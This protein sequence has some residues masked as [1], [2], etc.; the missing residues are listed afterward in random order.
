MQNQFMENDESQEAVPAAGNTSI[1][2]PKEAPKAKQNAGG[3]DPKQAFMGMFRDLKA[4][5]DLL[6]FT[7]FL[8]RYN[9]VRDDKDNDDPEWESV[10]MRVN[11]CNCDKLRAYGRDMN[12]SRLEQMYTVDLFEDYYARLF[13]KKEN[14]TEDVKNRCK[15]CTARDGQPHA[16]C[17]Y[18]AE[19]VIRR[20]AK[21][22]DMDQEKIYDDLLGDEKISFR[23][24][25]AYRLRQDLAKEE[26]SGIDAKSA[27]GA[28]LLLAARLI[29]VRA[30]GDGSVQYQYFPLCRGDK[31]ESIISQ[32]IDF[33]KTGAGIA[34]EL[35]AGDRASF[36]EEKSQGCGRCSYVQCPHKIA[37][38]A[39]LLGQKYNEDPIDV[40]YYLAKNCTV[41]GITTSENYEFDRFLAHINQ[42]PVTEESR[43]VFIKLIHYIVCRFKNVD[44][45]FL[46]MNLAIISPDREKAN[47]VANDFYD[48]FWFFDYLR[49]GK[50]R[51]TCRR[52][53]L[54][55]TS[56][57]EFAEQYQKANRGTCYFIYDI[58]LLLENKEFKSGYHRL[59]KLMDDRKDEVLS[60]LIGDKE[61]ISAFFEA[62]PAFRSKIFTKQIE[63][64][65]MDRTS[66]NTELLDKLK[67]YFN[68]S[69]EMQSRI[70]RYV[71]VAYASSPLRSMEF[72]KDL[73]EKIVFNHYNHDME[74]GNELVAADIP[75]LKPPRSEQSIFEELNRL[76]GLENV[77]KELRDVNNLVKFNIKMGSASRNAVNLHMVF[78]GN[79]GTG[80]T[81]VA[82]L[83]AEILHSIG[84]IQEDK[85]VVCSAKDLI[86]E[87]IGQ[88]TPKTAKKCEQAYNGV[89]FIDEAYQLNPYTSDHADPYKEECIA[90]LI[91][92]MEN[93]RDKMVVIF[94]GYTEEMETFLNSANTGL[95]SRIGKTIIFPDYSSDELLR[96]FEKMAS[97]S[98]MQLSDGAKKRAC[99]IFD[100][101]KS[102]A[103]RFG[104]ARFARSLFERS[105]MQ[106]A[107]NTADLSEND[108]DLRILQESEITPPQI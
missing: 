105:L 59:L 22:Y 44:V 28:Y 49:C 33:W 23:G 1:S 25:K 85:L 102:D 38:Y 27:Y 76:I 88:T 87:Y 77:K 42:A 80:K 5:K 68:V 36:L 56:Y 74:A 47:E 66:V 57:Q 75:Y 100:T 79:P 93:N 21:S 106:H 18:M 29:R 81:T 46:P 11:F 67:Q 61:E 8:H 97:D 103:K 50:G 12:M 92:Q 90:E 51:A 52:I 19:Q 73:Y 60:V 69:E 3:P 70:D 24:T 26:C 4:N 40:A 96:I 48:A 55:L 32:V 54:S 10:L 98:G 82:R 78:S 91:L 17:P 15:C 37:A 6:N 86:G 30:F 9:L 84:F 94:A 104:N 72:V 108:P 65:D 62:F 20:A 83:T 101:Y 35:Y 53:H 107:A 31:K 89:L 58:A 41:A 95:R 71:R 34:G 13:V 14:Y 45:P 2:V 63:M 7:Y 16:F 64:V 99:F 39:C 43:R